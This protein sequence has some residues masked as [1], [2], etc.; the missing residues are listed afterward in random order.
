MVN[1]LRRLAGRQATGP[2]PGAFRT[3]AAAV[4]D[5]G[6]VRSTNEDRALL[7]MQALD[8]AHGV[9]DRVSL[10]ALAD[11]MGGHQAGEV[12]SELAV[13]TAQ[14]SLRAAAKVPGAKALAQAL[15]DANAAVY[16]EAQRRPEQQGM[17]TTL[18][19]LLLR[20]DGAHYAWLGDSRIYHLHQGQ[21]R[22]LGEDD[23]VVRHLVND[24]TLTEAEAR[25][26][27]DRNVLAQ[28]LGT[29]P[30]IP[31]LHVAGPVP[32]SS[33]DTF[34]L[35]SDG[36]HDVVPEARIVQL[37]HDV[38]AAEACRRL[39]EEAK[40]NGSDDNISVA[41]VQILPLA[42][43]SAEAQAPSLRATVTREAPS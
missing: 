14:R 1:W 22:Q 5:V 40:R 43:Q 35:C 28:A 33:G 9:G 17:G 7:A 42:G 8:P 30:Q 24:G 21:M 32:I 13:E 11:G 15:I 34:M 38:P 20:D 2:Q 4:S 3:H 6:L 27:P 31:R 18:V 19:L 26:H 39:V 36:L 12:A 16:A 37:L 29:H 41:V 25:H 10:A 23:T